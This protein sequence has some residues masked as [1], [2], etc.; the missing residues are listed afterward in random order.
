MGYRLH[1]DKDGRV[2]IVRT[3]DTLWAEN[4]RG[5]GIGVGAKCD[6]SPAHSESPMGCKAYKCETSARF[7][8][9]AC[10][11]HINPKF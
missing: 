7:D 11:K 10:Y 5:R 6:Q 1:P 2:I 3:P 8:S 4:N 9:S